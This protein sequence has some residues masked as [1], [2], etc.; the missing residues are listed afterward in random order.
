[1]GGDRSAWE[2]SSTADRRCPFAPP[3]DPSVGEGQ[4]VFRHELQSL[5][6]VGDRC[7]RLSRLEL[8]R[9]AQAP[10]RSSA[11]SRLIT[12]DRSVMAFPVH[13]GSGGHGPGAKDL[14]ISRL[15]LE[16][17]IEVPDFRLCHRPTR[18]PGP[19]GR[20]TPPE[21][22]DSSLPWAASFAGD[23]TFSSEPAIGAGKVF[24]VPGLVDPLASDELAPALKLVGL[25]RRVRGEI[26][27][28]EHG[29][30]RMA[31]RKPPTVSQRPSDEIASVHAM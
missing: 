13:R 28:V 7:I 22:Q 26:L 1:M 4:P 10:G 17:P 24:D 18:R 14:R 30:P 6:R 31:G 3:G 27:E 23:E 16:Q 20:A 2:R 21:I 19:D 11:G 25:Q 9:A 15:S 12:A 8:G 29:Y 5:L